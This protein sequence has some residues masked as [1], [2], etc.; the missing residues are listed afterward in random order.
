MALIASAVL[1]FALA[2][3]ATQHLVRTFD[4]ALVGLVRYAVNL[5]ILLALFYPR[6]RRG[7]F[8]IRRRTL[9]IVRSLCLVTVSLLMGLAFQRLP[10]GEAISIL[11]LAPVG[12]MVLA[13][14][15]LGEKV[16]PM[17]WAG[18]AMCLVGVMMIARPGGGLPVVGV[19]LSLAGAVVS[20]IYHILSRALV[21]TETTVAL[22]VY[23]A[24]VG[25]VVFALLAP[26][27]EPIPA[28]RAFDAALFL[29]V[30]ALMTM[31]HFLFTSAFREA[32]ASFLVP[33]NYLHL[34]LAGGLGWVFFGHLPDGTAL[35]GMGLIALS[36]VATATRSAR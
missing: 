15:L 20:V 31:G 7:L 17:G 12:V 6:E 18:A 5:I 24:L 32:P 2:D 35:A 19:M 28:L 34:V 8:G 4:V 14:P 36:G 22:T 10:V 27:S 33:I 9:V 1:M 30:G 29:G 11:Y 16:Q 3:V 25:T 13:G 23:T 21:R 26:W